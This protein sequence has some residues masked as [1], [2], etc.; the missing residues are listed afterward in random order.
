[1]DPQ[2]EV[3]KIVGETKPIAPIAAI[4]ILK[5]RAKSTML[6]LLGAAE[7]IPV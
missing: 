6:Y 3:I 4:K 5:R 2:D 7:S 1:M